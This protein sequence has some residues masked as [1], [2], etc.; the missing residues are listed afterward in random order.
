M[1]VLYALAG[2]LAIIMASGCSTRNAYE[3]L[4]FHQEMD[5]QRLQAADRDACL[6]SSGMSYDEYQKQL[7]DRDQAR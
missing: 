1:K 6:R 7:K 3:G 2:T 5:C 4:R